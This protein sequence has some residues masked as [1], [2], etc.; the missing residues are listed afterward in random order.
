MGFISLGCFRRMRP[1]FACDDESNPNEQICYGCTSTS[2]CFQYDVVLQV[3]NFWEK[4]RE[5]WIRRSKH[6][7]IGGECL[8]HGGFIWMEVAAAGQNDDEKSRTVE[9]G[10]TYGTALA[11][12]DE[13]LEERPILHLRLRITQTRR[14]VIDV[15]QCQHF[16]FKN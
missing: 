2:T 9:E 10:G 3:G 6:I 5:I 13:E 7:G 15:A 12:F 11:R 4:E 1:V 14:F 16:K 8:S